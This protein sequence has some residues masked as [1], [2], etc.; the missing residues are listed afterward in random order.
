VLIVLGVLAAAWLALLIPEQAPDVPEGAGR[1]P[2]VWGQ[3]DVWEALDA[4]Y[5][6]ARRRGCSALAGEIALAIDEIRDL[7]GL[8]AVSRLAP[9][10]VELVTIERRVFASAP[11]VAACPDRARE[12]IA[13]VEWMRRVV[14]EQS[15][16]WDPH[17]RASRVRNYRLLYGGRAAIEEV[18]L[19]IPGWAIGNLTLHHEE[20]SRSPSVVV[21]G[22]RIH[23][24]DLL[25][26]RGGAPTSALIARGNDFPGNF[27]HVALV[28][29]DRAGTASV[30]ES[31]IESGVIVGTAEQY[32]ADKKLRILV[33][34]PRADLPA[35]R[36]RPTIPHEAAERALR[37]ARSRHIPYDF[38]MDTRD[39]REQFCSEVASAPYGTLGIPLWEGQSSMSGPGVTGWLASFGVRHFET[40]APS[41]LEYDPKLRVVAEWR[42]PQALWQ[43]HL[44]NAVIDGMLEHAD[45]GA[46][47]EH[48][49]WLLPIARAMKAWSM[50]KNAMG[51]VGPVPEGMS[52]T[53]AL[54][55][56]WLRARHREVKDRV[57]A[58]ADRHRREHGYRAPYWTLVRFAREEAGR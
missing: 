19:Q 41:D 30:I 51:D 36:A 48:A 7:N 40:H 39:P 56:E 21:H 23:S 50:V 25:V 3:D 14:K 45:R 5:R 6:E 55:A 27:S 52:A 13:Q 4:R 15:A 22:V 44:D 42:D 37:D 11:L 31:H 16:R 17:D 34:R 12:W 1:E 26:S 32:L 2:F 24:G 46:R 29:V 43:D 20:P 58:R 54:R 53:V 38:A 57:Q 33:L 10:A 18:I 28:H 8:L 35:L 49:W 9:D 47:V